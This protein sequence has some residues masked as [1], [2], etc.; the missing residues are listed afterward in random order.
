M[1]GEPAYTDAELEVAVEAYFKKH[2]GLARDCVAAA[3]EAVAPAIAARALR[4]AADAV[5]PGWG[6]LR[7]PDGRNYYGAQHVP[8][9]FNERG[10]PLLDWLR[11]RAAEIEAP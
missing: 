6:D 11:N 7:L 4:E 9:D 5:R 8:D 1:T 3:L 2:S 10:L